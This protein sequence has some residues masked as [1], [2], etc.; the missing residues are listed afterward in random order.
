MLHGKATWLLSTLMMYSAGVGV[1]FTDFFLQRDRV[2]KN[3]VWNDF[4]FTQR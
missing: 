2:L 3:M 1:W 4:V